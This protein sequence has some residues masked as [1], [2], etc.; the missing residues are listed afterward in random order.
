MKPILVIIIF[1]FVGNSFVF[2]QDV[3]FE[4][5]RKLSHPRLLLLKNE[6]K[7]ILKSFEED[8]QLL[9]VNNQII[10]AC[11]KI[12]KMEPLQRKQVGRRLLATSREALRR[13][14]FLSY[15]WRVTKERKY[16][17]RAEKELLSVS[18]FTDWNPSHFLDV[19]EMTLGVAIGYD[20]LY[21]NLSDNSRRIIASAIL[22]KGIKPS[23]D[24]K[25]N[26]FLTADNNWNQVCNAGMLFGA[27]AIY[28]KNSALAGEIIQRS[29][30]SVKL[31]MK[32]YGPDGAYPEGYNYWSYGTSFNVMLLDA[33]ERVFDYDF[34]LTTPPGFLRT[35]E[36]YMHMVG[37]SGQNFNYSDSGTG[38]GL[39]PTMF[40]FAN[41][42]G[43]RSLLYAERIKITDSKRMRAEGD[44]LLPSLILWNRNKPLN[45]VSIP[46]KNMWIG[47]GKTPVVLMRT[48]W[49]DKDALF[50]G[51]K[52]GT[53]S[54]NH[55]HMDIGSFVMDADGVRWAMDPG[56]QNYESL[57]SK[58]LSIFE[59]DQNAQRWQVFRMTNYVHNTLTVNRKLQNVKGFAPLELV[60]NNAKKKMATAN[61]TQIYPD[62]FF[63][64]FRSAGI[65]DDKYV[66]IKD[67][68][69]TKSGRSIR[70][71][72]LTPAKVT[73]IGNG[74]LLS[75]QGKDMVMVVKGIDVK[76]KTWS[77]EPPQS[78][79][80]PMPETT[81]IG[82]EITAPENAN[83][84]YSVYLI[85]ASNLPFYKNQNKL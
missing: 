23:I 85:P 61:L 63:S 56:M 30:N 32:E 35:A 7:K 79:D 73:V 65:I 68:L 64:A 60:S 46:E 15:A 8:A 80:A 66:E 27:L 1:S 5:V 16:L 58:G 40:W 34:E 47:Q 76:W 59:R 3:D 41:R 52:G 33:L 11:E 78:Y 28:E 37:S 22:E 17:E 67:S 4:K 43:D 24:K 45:A 12:I 53:A 83:I 42:T 36:Y 38:V 9:I 77:T 57:E 50:L 18:G 49:G 69:Q 21:D 48:Q 84:T 75:Q 31:S 62:D 2:A 10:D 82:F 70:W 44:R 74:V 13:I 39:N 81:F 71:N 51:F 19:A 14:Y 25:H 55:A 20:W 29:I 54:T 6:E 26:N 72:M